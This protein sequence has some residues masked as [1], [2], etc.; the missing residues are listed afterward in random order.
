MG[1]EVSSEFKTA[2]G[3][4]LVG[5][6][7]NYTIPN[8][9]NYSET[10]IEYTR[11]GL[12]TADKLGKYA[13]YEKADDYEQVFGVAEKKYKEAL[14]QLKLRGRNY[15]AEQRIMSL[16]YDINKMIFPIALSEGILVM[17]EEMFGVSD[18]F[19]K[20]PQDNMPPRRR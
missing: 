8:A 20:S 14:E 4:M 10:L 13:N 11:A 9:L 6:K 17:N 19:T 5:L 7:M 16:C 3:R 12:V 2:F 1:K 18:M 15:I